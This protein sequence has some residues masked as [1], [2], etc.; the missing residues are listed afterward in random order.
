[1]AMSDEDL[2]QEMTEQVKAMEDTFVEVPKDYI[3]IL[4]N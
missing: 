1:M 2:V 3:K 4:N